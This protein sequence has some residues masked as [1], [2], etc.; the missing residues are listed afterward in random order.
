MDNVEMSIDPS[1]LLSDM[2]SNE[3]FLDNAID[4][5]HAG[6]AEMVKMR[7]DLDDRI[8]RSEKMLGQLIAHKTL[9]GMV[10]NGKA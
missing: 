3:T 10:K 4:Q 2:L 9:F 7:G 1:K 5:V 8:A 6:I